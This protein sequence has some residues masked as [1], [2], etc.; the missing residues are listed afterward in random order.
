[1]RADGGAALDG[2]HAVLVQARRFTRACGQ[3]VIR[4]VLGVHRPAFEKGHRLLQHR[5]IARGEH[6]ARHRPGQPQVVVGAMRAH[7]AA[8]GRVP[9]VLHVAFVELMSR[10][11]QQVLACKARLGMDQRHRVLELI[12]EAE[13]AAGLV[14]AAARPEAASERLVQ[15]ATRSPAGRRSARAFPPAP[16]PA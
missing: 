4:V 12:A 2:T 1:V 11:A 7:A 16:R 3:V 8:R 5:G 14:V 9:P 6:V 10:A 13:G 15:R